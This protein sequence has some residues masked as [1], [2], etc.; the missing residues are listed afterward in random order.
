MKSRH[1]FFATLIA[2]VL[3]GMTAALAVA[4]PTLS[5]SPTV[6]E[7]G[8]TV[9]MTTSGFNPGGYNATLVVDFVPIQDIYIPAG[10]ART[11]T[12]YAPTDIAIGGHDIY[13]CASCSQGDLEEVTN[14][15]RITVVSGNL[16]GNE[17]NLQPWAM[18]VTQGVRAGFAVRTPP[19]AS[20]DLADEP[21]VHVANRRTVVRLY[22][23]VEGGPLFSRV[24]SVRARLWVTR[25]GVT[26]GPIASVA[27][28]V[29]I[30][31]PEA[32]IDDVRANMQSTWNFILPPEATSLAS[33]ETSGSFDLMVE[34]NPDG[35]WHHAECATCFDD[36]T[37]T[38][39]NN[40]I[41]HVG[42][43]NNYGL[44]LR[45]HLM[46]ANVVQADSSTNF[47]RRPTVSEYIS[48][49]RKMFDVLPIAD[50]NRG[51]RLMPWRIADW[52]GTQDEW[53]PVQDDFLITNFLPGGDLVSAPPNDFY[54]FFYSGDTNCGG[55]AKRASP[56]FR[57]STCTHS[58]IAAHELNHAIGAA[59]AGNGHGENEGGG[60]DHDYPG[61]HGQVEDYSW[62]VNVYNLQLYPPRIPLSD[63]EVHDFMSY[64]GT[65]EWVS[66]Y[67]WNLAAENL[68]TPEIS[69]DKANA[70][71][72]YRKFPGVDKSTANVLDYV[73]FRGRYDNVGPIELAA[74]L[75]SWEP[76]GNQGDGT[77][78]LE[79]TDASGAFLTS[80]SPTLNRFQDIDQSFGMFAEAVALPVGWQEMTLREGNTVVQTWTRSAN[81]P[82]VNLIS[83]APN[84]QWANTGN[85]TIDWTASDADGDQLV[86]RLLGQQGTDNEVFTL[87]ADLTAMSVTL[88]LSK[89]PGGGDWTLQLE[90]S[91]GFDRTTSQLV[92]GSMDPTPPQVGILEPKPDSI[93]LVDQTIVAMGLSADLQGDIDDGNMAWYLDGTWVGA[94]SSFE[95]PA[96]TVGVH[97]LELIVHN[98][99]QL[100]G[101]SA[102]QFEVLNQLVTPQL[103]APANGTTGTS[104]AVQLDW[105]PVPGAVSYRV[106]V[107]DTPEF[108]GQVG[109]VGN[110]T[111]SEGTFNIPLDVNFEVFWRIMAEHGSGP[112]AW[113]ETWSFTPENSVTSVDEVPQQ[114]ATTLTAY[115][116]PFNPATKI[117]FD[118]SQSGKVSVEIYDLTGRLVRA[119]YR[120]NKEAGHHELIWNG[121]D[122][123]AMGVS[124]G[125][126]LVRL[127]T[128]QGALNH[129]VQLLK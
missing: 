2:V 31:R 116:N 72:R 59:H 21:A 66:N 20:F 10:G 86:Y 76:N 6:V 51:I 96:A 119:L 30:V 60:Y 94:G 57:S 68:G 92:S 11:F 35:P 16:T 78:D 84:F 5:I 29:S 43:S 14:D 45:G 26:Y 83:P 37:I 87:A 27:P 104:H 9:V 8:G 39:N 17:Y 127:V 61:W 50:G 122:E 52:N 97:Q 46:E 18:E 47:V 90:A 58:Y 115:P 4:A 49:V 75:G 48:T 81:P 95:L 24:Y 106:I 19:D 63:I 62:G 53:D 112:S 118:L 67:S 124:S 80:V 128:A 129:R 40:E 70:G 102:I 69:L 41:R 64:G 85:V 44:K 120:G 93:F 73:S 121:R 103:T 33:T 109:E 36:N 25:D 99:H 7:P 110:I 125:S 23:W 55:H 79:F 126:Y 111:E 113:S 108:G 74:F 123:R 12:W 13:L 98:N 101:S 65:I 89:L 22:P 1:T 42:R 38:L 56:F 15:V 91:D 114:L 105:D 107:G 71:L 82:Q 100:A 54:G 32:T 28:N 117:A 77:F 88:N 3:W 34:I